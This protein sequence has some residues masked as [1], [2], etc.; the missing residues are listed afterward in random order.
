MTALHVISN[1]E[2][3]V[4]EYVS[5]SKFRF[6]TEP[7]I[8]AVSRSCIFPTPPPNSDTA[9]VMDIA[10]IH[11]PDVLKCETSI[12]GLVDPFQKPPETKDCVHLVYFEDGDQKFSING[13]IIPSRR[14]DTYMYSAFKAHS[15]EGSSGAPLLI[16]SED[17]K[18][19]MVGGVHYEGYGRDEGGR[20]L[21]FSGKN[22]LQHTLSPAVDI[23]A[24]NRITNTSHQVIA[25]HVNTV[26]ERLEEHLREHRLR[27]IINRPQPGC[28]TGVF[29]H[30]TFHP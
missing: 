3:M 13:K 15:P 14:V 21:W 9:E 19:F 2:T 10:L 25:S 16:F 27:V 23:V 26:C 28:V 7:E 29:Q 5:Q 17:R 11:V 6:P 24:E 20:A 12:P 4:A 22:W 30:V 18:K 8:K 1:D